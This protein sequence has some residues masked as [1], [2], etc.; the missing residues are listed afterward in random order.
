MSTK[1]TISYN[2]EDE[3]FDYHF[4]EEA[5]DTNYVWFQLPAEIAGEKQSLTIK[6]PIRV[7]RKIVKDW[8]NC[9]W[10]KDEAR[11][12]TE[13]EVSEG[14]LMFLKQLLIPDD[15]DDK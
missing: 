5:W 11:D 3:G 15:E 14:S 10:A 1:C 2:E 12:N 4:Y 8:E 6:F 7:W 9:G 13:I